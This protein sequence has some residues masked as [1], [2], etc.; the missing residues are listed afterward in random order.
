MNWFNVA[1]LEIYLPNYIGM[2]Q[3]LFLLSYYRIY[4]EKNILLVRN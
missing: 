4:K 3:L 2:Y 1:D